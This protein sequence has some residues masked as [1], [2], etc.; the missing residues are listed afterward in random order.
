M[1]SSQEGNS[2]VSAEHKRPLYAFLVVCLICGLIIG[3]TLRSQALELL[4]P[5]LP[6]LVIAAGTTLH[7]AAPVLGGAVLEPA[8]AAEPDRAAPLREHGIKPASGD[9][10]PRP[11]E[12][13]RTRSE[14][15]ETGASAVPREDRDRGGQAAARPRQADGSSDRIEGRTVVFRSVVRG[16]GDQFTVEEGGAPAQPPATAEPVTTAEPAKQPT[17]A[18]ERSQDSRSDRGNDAKADRKNGPKADRGNGPKA[19]RGNDPKSDRKSDPK[20]PH[21]AEIKPDHKATGPNG[22]EGG[23]KDDGNHN[24]T[25]NGNSLARQDRKDHRRLQHRSLPRRHRPSMP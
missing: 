9:R 6:P 4:R 19:D 8:T 3:H 12:L 22:R 14:G 10:A 18:T 5:V 16:K 11:G 13:A 24:G 23:R 25:D 15:A 21:K 20:F 2:A 17:E 7:A 1:S